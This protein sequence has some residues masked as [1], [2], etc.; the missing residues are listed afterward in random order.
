VSASEETAAAEAHEELR[1]AAAHG[2]RWSVISRPLIEVIQLASIVVLARL[3]DPAEFG[4][5]AIALI[6]QEIAFLIVA[7]GLSAALVQRVKLTRAHEETGLALGLTFGLAL[8]LLTVLVASVVVAPVFGGR[9]A[10][11]V[12]LMAPLCVV[13]AVSVVPMA[14]LRRRMAFRRLSEIEIASTFARVG[15]SVALAAIGMSGE[16]LI[17][18]VISGSLVTAIFSWASA[19]GPLPRF[20]RGPA[21]EL[22]DY[23]LPF[24]LA[25]VSWIGFSNVD[26]A[27]IGARLGAV[28]TGLYYRAYTLAVEYQAKVSVVMTQVGFPVLSRTDGPDELHRLHRQMVRMLTILLF[29]LLALLAIGAPVLV[30]LC[31]GSDWSGAVVPVQ[32][33]AIGGASTLAIDA[34]GTVLMAT[35]RTRALLGYGVAHFLAYGAAVVIVAG[36]GIVAVA[37][38]GSV[39]HTAFLFVA[40]ALVL[41]DSE[42]APLRRLWSDIGPATVT[43]LCL[44][45]TGLP[46]GL[47]LTAAGIPAVPWLLGVGLA[48]IPTYLLALRLLFPAAWREQRSALARILPRRP[49]LGGGL[50]D[51]RPTT[52]ERAPA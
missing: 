14:T 34:A 13:A 52:T 48:S 32:I 49:R 46:A 23:G 41:R 40:Y 43:S 31:F 7:G 20:H 42:E 33:L 4:R 15:I 24:S 26:Y 6:A 38:A 22:L 5:Y 8:G 27:I 28:Q 50:G 11:F 17:I 1:D 39:V 19:P 47:G 9:T 35:G 44:V 16:A 36:H 10:F 21:R 45:A 3:V 12:H 29:P 2:V 18:G 30:P 25:S 51:S 37:V